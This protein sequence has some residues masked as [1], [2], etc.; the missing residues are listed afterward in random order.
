MSYE[1]EM[2]TQQGWV[3]PQCGRV[4]APWMSMCDYCCRKTI[5][6]ADRTSGMPIS[7]W[8]KST[9]SSGENYTINSSSRCDYPNNVCENH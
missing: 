7:E 3:C 5:T 8:G 6:V 1:F 4:Y 9:T 2:P